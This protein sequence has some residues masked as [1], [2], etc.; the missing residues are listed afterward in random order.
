M[1]ILYTRISEWSADWARNLGANTML[2]NQPGGYAEMGIYSAANQ[3]GTRSRSYRV[4]WRRWR[5]HFYLVSTGSE[6]PRITV[7]LFAGT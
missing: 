3:W 7:R 5:C 6:I 4:S 1:V 2:V